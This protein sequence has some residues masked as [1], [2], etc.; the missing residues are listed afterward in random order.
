MVKAARI[1]ADDV[2]D[3][4]PAGRLIGRRLVHVS[5]R[6]RVHRLDAS[7][8]GGEPVGAAP[9]AALEREP[10]SVQ[11]DRPVR[12]QERRRVQQRASAPGIGGGQVLPAVD[13]R[14]CCRQ[15]ARLSRADVEPGGHH[16]RADR[17]Q[18][19][20]ERAASHSRQ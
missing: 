16:E 13:D 15:V 14:A 3:R 5:P 8:C 18:D 19:G 20:E 7:D 2:C 10:R 12:V 9:I 11:L 4:G 17:R 6:G 1:Q